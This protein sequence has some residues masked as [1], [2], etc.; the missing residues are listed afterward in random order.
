MLEDLA[1][2]K[3]S[4]MVWFFCVRDWRIPA[5]ECLNLSV[6]YQ[7]FPPGLYSCTVTFKV[8]VQTAGG[9][10]LNVLE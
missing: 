2:F 8:F 7:P 10:E 9:Q 4:T 6:V 5:S 1:N 3:A